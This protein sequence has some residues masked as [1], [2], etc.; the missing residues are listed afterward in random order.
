[1]ADP[2]AYLE[3]EPITYEEIEIIARHSELVIAKIEQLATLVGENSYLAK[4]TTE[5]KKKMKELT[6]YLADYFDA[7]RNRKKLPKQEERKPNKT[8]WPVTL[9]KHALE[10]Y[11]ILRYASQW[12]RK[13]KRCLLCLVKSI[14]DFDIRW[15][16]ALTVRFCQIFV[17]FC[18]VA[19]FMSN[20]KLLHFI[21]LLITAYHADIPDMENDVREF[22]LVNNFITQALS[23]PCK[24]IKQHTDPQG[25]LSEKLN[26]LAATTGTYIAQLMGQFPLIDWSVFSIFSKP[27]E[28]P[29]TTLSEDDFFILQHVNLLKETMLY[30]V[31]IFPKKNSDGS[32]ENSFDVV[33]ENLLT[34]GPF[35]PITIS[36]KIPI[37]K[38]IR[39]NKGA[40]SSDMAKLI[41]I[42]ASR[43]FGTAHRK[44]IQNI[45][46]LLTEIKNMCEFDIRLL[47]QYFSNII[48]LCSL[49]Y[50]E[51]LSY[52]HF[53]TICVDALD[54]LAVMLDL[55]KLIFKHKEDIQR[56]YLFNLSTIDIQY[57]KKL[58]EQ[59]GNDQIFPLIQPLIN[60]LEV[61][62]LEDFDR[63]DQYHYYAFKIT[64]GRI[65]LFYN[66]LRQTSVVSYAESIFEHLT[67]IMSH[68]EYAEDP[69]R[70]I[71]KYCPISTLWV[72]KEHFMKHVTTPIIPLSKCITI[73]EIC[74]YFELD[75]NIYAYP[76]M[77]GEI[78]M[79]YKQVQGSLLS[80][81]LNELMRQCDPS[82]LF[83]Q[84]GL[85]T[86]DLSR[87]SLFNVRLFKEQSDKLSNATANS[88]T[89]QNT[90]Q[91]ELRSCFTRMPQHIRIFDLVENPS[92]FFEDKIT[93]SFSN[94]LF[95]AG[96]VPDSLNVDRGFSTAFQMIWQI[97]AQMGKPFQRNMFI[98]RHQ[99]GTT[100]DSEPYLQQ[101]N[102]L[103]G[104][105]EFTDFISE[106]PNLV[107]KLANKC[108]EFVKSGY[109][110]TLYLTPLHGFYNLEKTDLM[111][112]DYFSANAIHYTIKN[113]GVNAGLAYDRVV[114][115]VAARSITKIFKKFLEI[116]N[117][118]SI[119]HNSF[120]SSTQLPPESLSSPVFNE[121][122]EEMIRLGCTMTLRV[123]ILDEMR[124]CISTAVPGL[125]QM[126]DAA[127]DRITV[128]LSGKEQLICETVSHRDSMYFIQ[129]IIEL[130]KIDKQTDFI[131]FMF[132]IGLLLNNSK[133]DDIKYHTDYDSI[134][135]NLHLFP[136]AL[137]AFIEVRNTLFISADDLAM[138]AGVKTLYQTFGA[139]VNSKK[140]V[141]GPNYAKA[142][143]KLA[144]T[145]PKVIDVLQF[146][147]ISE[148]FPNYS[149]DLSKVQ[150]TSNSKKSRKEEKKSP[151]D[152]QKDKKSTK[153]K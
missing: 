113:L 118:L 101:V 25:L 132:F 35:V 63:G 116:S 76:E 33:V 144:I 48:S 146:G 93:D 34:E 1:M 50:Y 130:Q 15:N 150:F 65:L 9:L 22:V 4:E 151:R 54:L 37:E 19:I 71:F 81:L 126:V 152:S 82:G 72:E 74:A 138:E 139:V 28:T 147:W 133:W 136:I 58:V 77:A 83:Y 47:S 45:T 68:I 20:F 62:N 18:R 141:N 21:S 86:R 60:A 91:S 104:S 61:L 59:I 46:I 97:F 107:E 44:R 80:R 102:L 135:Y 122:C 96:S 112:S 140:E 143:T 149:I 38:F 145:F 125:E 153:K 57:L 66:Q 14:S 12:C 114:T 84:L 115:H 78:K 127:M 53:N 11:I 121:C 99:E 7:L 123:I 5:K 94:F 49:G 90:I 134:S 69:I 85:Q 148:V 16:Q 142:T 75:P 43:K 24:M 36:M 89:K 124:K 87:N 120:K 39:L 109:K 40:I 51:F 88:F 2:N 106:R 17:T 41:P 27:T 98:A 23:D 73:L 111:T 128:T 110:K 13:A 129:Q 100:K 79:A 29:E 3:E 8:P 105:I 6:K 52:F 30:F 103:N 70:T 26:R 10:P 31:M 117:D 108:L 131:K 64:Y 67:T 92:Q 55:I 137:N 56:F 32:G 119:W 95:P 42:V